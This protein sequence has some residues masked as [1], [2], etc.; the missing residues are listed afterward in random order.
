MKTKSLNPGDQVS[1]QSKSRKWEGHILESHDPEVILLKLKSGYNIG[2]RESEI[3]E[4]KTIKRADTKEKEK[5]KRKPNKSLPTIAMIVTGGTISSRLDPKSGGVISTDVEE[6]LNIAPEIKE[7]ANIIIDKPF[8]KWSENMAFKDWKILAETCEKYLNDKSI[9]G[10]IITH[11]TDFLHYTA[12]ALSYF[13]KDLNK[14]IALTY[15]Q[16][17]I[18]RASTDAA[19]NLIAA[20]KYATSDIAEVALV[21]HENTNDET[22]LAMPGKQVRKLHTSA[23]DAFKIINAEPLARITSDSLEILKEFN[24]R[25]NSKSATLDTKFSDKVASIK[26]TPGQDPAIIEFYQS[27]GY[28]GLVLEITG[29][30]QVPAQDAKHNWLPKIKSAIKDGMTIIGTAQTINGRLN[31]NVYSAGRDLQKTGIIFSS[32]TTETALVKLGWVLGHKQWNK[33]EKF[34]TK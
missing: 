9:T 33:K 14:P 8:V 22:C 7:T 25:D 32:L 5:E 2:I 31:P 26:I 17:S 3:L 13:I 28:K 4:V 24:A 10:I 19:L 20:A 34:L 29:I 11:G 12:A 23:R 18:D 21:G 15:S 6:I 16:K 30:G 1:L 27:L